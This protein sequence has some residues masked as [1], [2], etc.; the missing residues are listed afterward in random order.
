MSVAPVRYAHFGA[1]SVLHKN[2]YGCFSVASSTSA[3]RSMLVDV[4][5]GLAFLDLTDDSLSIRD[6]VLL[7]SGT[8]LEF[9]P[10]RQGGRYSKANNTQRRYY[11]SRIPFAVDVVPVD[12]L[13]YVQNERICIQY[14]DVDWVS[15]NEEGSS[16][17][18]S[19]SGWSNGKPFSILVVQMKTDSIRS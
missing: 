19:S 16:I 9:S 7:Y 5:F 14:C 15:S 18:M 1:L 4:V 6:L 11:C 13:I 2:Q 17:S 3:Y 12:Y 10:L 8:H